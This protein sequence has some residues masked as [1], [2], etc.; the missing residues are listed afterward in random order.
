MSLQRLKQASVAHGSDGAALTFRL[1]GRADASHRLALIH[2]LAMDHRFWEDVIAQLPP[3]VSVLSFDARGHGT[4]ERGMARFTVETFADDLAALFD[5]VGWSDAVVA[6]ASMGGS[7][8]LAFA[9]NHWSRVKALGLFDTTAWY[10]DDAA[11]QW[12]ERAGK[13]REKGLAA[14]VPFQVTRWFGDAFRETNAAT[15]ARCVETFTGN[16]IESYQSSCAML[17]ACDLRQGL[18]SVRVPTSILVGEED[19]AT[20]V[21]MAQALHDGIAGSTLHVIEGAR[22]LTPLECPK[23]IAAELYRL[24]K[25]TAR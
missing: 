22:H 20:P 13:A 1:D 6:G 23:I 7:V 8:A 18:G 19:Y 9:I 24:T 21:A 4:S 5:E 11:E 17:G 10:G 3:D 15:V 14:L 12:A 16:D 25:D 2:S